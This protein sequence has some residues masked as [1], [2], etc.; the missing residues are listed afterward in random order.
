MDIEVLEREA[1]KLPADERARLARELLNSLDDL[2]EAEIDRLWLEEVSR[3]ATQIDAGEVEL[4][5]GE[6]VDRKAQALLR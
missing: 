3:R 1:L 2:P 6:E 4:V 5:S